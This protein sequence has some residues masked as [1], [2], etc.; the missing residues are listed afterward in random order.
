MKNLENFKNII[1][2]N[3]YKMDLS[4]NA[5]NSIKAKIEQRRTV[6]KIL[7]PCATFSSGLVVLVA[8]FLVI[9]G[10]W[11][12]VVTNA[13][14][15]MSGIEP[16]HV[17]GLD[18]QKKDELITPVADFSV[19]LLKE[20]YV[21]NKNTL[22]SPLSMYLALGMTANGSNGETLEEFED[23]LGMGADINDLN[24][25]YKQLTDRI[26]N[27]KEVEVKV[28]NSIWYNS[29]DTLNVKADFLQKNANYYGASAYKANFE[30]SS[31]VND[32]NNWVKKKTNGSVDKIINEIPQN[33]QMFLVNA[34]YFEGKWLKDYKKKDIKKDIFHALNGD[35]E[36]AFMHSKE[37]LYIF[38]ENAQGFIK[39]YKGG[40]FSFVGILP[41]EGISAEKYT[42]DLTGESFLELLSSRIKDSVALSLPK[43]ETEFELSMN[44]SLK[45]MG[46]VK[47]FQ[48]ADFS[49]MSD[50]AEGLYIKD[51]L[52]KVYLDVS[53]HGTKAVSVSLFKNATKS[54]PGFYLKFDRP[55][56]YA[57]I[58][59]ETNLPLFIGILQ[60]PKA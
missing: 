54:S 46:L 35:V 47:A 26:I 19:R 60:N 16:Q 3:L 52:H 57:I 1:D 53:E 8:V 25:F 23:V 14:D 38:D 33:T 10:I 12:S 18:R 22:I 11:G 36:T 45:K 31:T 2:S 5:K 56:I 44:D 30:D 29:T 28:A 40:K 17:E 41:Q 7:W 13:Q 50:T 37:S 58:D 6:R 49:N 51:M 15:L 20:A 9:N 48:D 4:D 27:H 24:I 21:S 43:F 32:I 39:P 34:L 42:E 55:F 59:N